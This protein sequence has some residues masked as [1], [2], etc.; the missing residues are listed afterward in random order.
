MSDCATDPEY[1]RYQYGDA[2]KLRLRQQSHALYSE[3]QRSFFD[4]LMPRSI[5]SRGR[6]CWTL[7]AAPACSIRCW[8]LT[9]RAS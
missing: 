3:E 4:W 2:G 7:A 8:L 5:R 6:S 1:L 9:A